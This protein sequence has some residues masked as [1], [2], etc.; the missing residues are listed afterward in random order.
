MT[1]SQRF[2]IPE[3]LPGMN[4]IIDAR[5]R[6]IT[7]KRGNRRYRISKYD[8]LKKK[9]ERVILESINGAHLKPMR[10]VNALFCWVEPK[11]NR[12]KDNISAAKKFIFDALV[13]AGIIN[14]DGWRYVSGFSDDFVINADKPGVW[15]TL[16]E[17]ENE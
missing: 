15:V 13:G 9:T 5:L 7:I 1:G 4:E 11:R 2:F 10:Y 12:D 17:V 14:G 16:E 3:R 6:Y 8:N